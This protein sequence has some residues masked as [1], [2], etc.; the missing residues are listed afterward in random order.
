MQT[1]RTRISKLEQRI[2]PPS[3]GKYIVVRGCS[4]DADISDLLRA[5]GIDAGNPVH[6]I[7]S[8]QRFFVASDSA[9]TKPLARPEILH[10]MD[11]K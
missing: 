9:E 8:L 2:S 3:P 10:V 1:T 4:T 5:N 11:K 6:T 7:I